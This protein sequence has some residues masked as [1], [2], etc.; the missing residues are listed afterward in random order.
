MYEKFENILLAIAISIIIL[1][2]LQFFKPQEK[3]FY[4]E[5]YNIL[6]PFRVNYNESLKIKVINEDILN[7]SLELLLT[8]FFKNV[9]ISFF[10]NDNLASIQK[11]AYQIVMVLS[12]VKSYKNLK[13]SIEGNKDG[14]DFFIIFLKEKDCKESYV[15]AENISFVEICGKNE[16]ELELSSARFLVYLLEKSKKL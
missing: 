13:F 12:I 11:S 10:E 3:I 1:I 2:I 6:I 9:S 7:L 8:N 15:K 16:K 5:F 4:Y 14:K